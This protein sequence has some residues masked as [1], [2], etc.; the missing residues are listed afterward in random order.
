MEE[1]LDALART[2]AAERGVLLIESHMDSA[3]VAARGAS[4]LDRRRAERVRAELALRGVRADDMWI[5]NYGAARPM[6][7]TRPGVGDMNNRRVSV[8]LPMA[9][10]I[11]RSERRR[12]R[13]EWFQRNCYP[14]PATAR[15]QECN[16]ALEDIRTG[17]VGSV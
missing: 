16:R 6:V 1:R 10:A 4:N 2:Y 7:P 15:R 3:E 11:C 9:G 12:E 17:N 14:L 13:V 8:R 5:R